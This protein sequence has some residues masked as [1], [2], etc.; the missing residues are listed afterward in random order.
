MDEV[1]E[2]ATRARV[3]DLGGSEHELGDVWAERPVLLV[4]LRHFG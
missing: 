2:A 1:P 4:F 3:L